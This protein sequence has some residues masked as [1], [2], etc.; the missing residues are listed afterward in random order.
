ML[1][2]LL[3][4]SL[5]FSS[6]WYFRHQLAASY[7]PLG[8]RYAN[9]SQYRFSL[10]DQEGSTLFDKT[11]LGA[12]LYSELT[13]AY[14]R[15]GPRLSFAPIAIFDMNLEAVGSYY[16]GT[17]SGITDFDTVDFPYLNVDAF[18]AQKEDRRSAGMGVRLSLAPTLKARVKDIV[19]AIPFEVQHFVMRPPDD[20]TG[21]F[22]YEPQADVIM[23]FQDTIMSAGVVAFYAIT[24][25]TKEDP[26]FY[27]AGA[28][29][30]YQKVLGTGDTS[31]KAG[32]MVVFHPGTGKYVPTIVVFSEV[33]L[34]EQLEG[35]RPG[36]TYPA[37][38]PY[39][40]FALIW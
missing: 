5:A 14:I 33:Y 36:Q 27:W 11:Y 2:L 24:D 37:F 8:L 9:T 13:P 35:G 28:R 20:S 39:T 12:G 31:A 34:D 21:P 3:S 16:F 1:G 22:F 7:W 18:E 40:A 6:E 19:V 23:K 17:F 25:D 4:S 29:A 15:V 26:R 30:D 10:W 32:P 38:P